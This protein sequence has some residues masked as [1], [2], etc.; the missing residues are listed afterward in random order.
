MLACL[1]RD[2]VKYEV[3]ENRVQPLHIAD[4]IH[5]LGKLLAVY[6]TVSAASYWAFYP[7]F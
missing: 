5:I 1:E 4:A 6:I 3:R 7:S 2:R